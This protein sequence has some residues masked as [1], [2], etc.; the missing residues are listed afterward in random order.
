MEASRGG[1]LA[2]AGAELAF[3]SFG[4]L[5]A[6][7]CAFKCENRHM[8]G[9]MCPVHSARRAHACMCHATTP[10]HDA[11]ALRKYELW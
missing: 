10:F 1:P 5:E 7:A 2:T 9:L 4:W 8:P 6:N 3:S 11:E